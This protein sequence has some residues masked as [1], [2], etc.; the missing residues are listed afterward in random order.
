MGL[1]ELAPFI[2]AEAKRMHVLL[3]MRTQTLLLT[4]FPFL[5]PPRRLHLQACHLQVCNK[6]AK[7]SRKEKFLFPT[8]RTKVPALILLVPIGSYAHPGTRRM[9]E[10]STV[11]GQLDPMPTWVEAGVNTTQLCGLRMREAI[12]RRKIWGAGTRQ[13]GDGGCETDQTT[14]V[15]HRAFQ[16]I[17][18]QVL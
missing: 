17:K 16:F 8:V 4:I 6:V 12:S 14:D 1:H 10:C 9:G 7:F 3:Y 13:S 2:L 5:S 15:D 18:H 11:F